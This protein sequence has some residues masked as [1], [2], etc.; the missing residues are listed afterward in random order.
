MHGHLNI[1]SGILFYLTTR[2]P[3]TQRL[4]R[5]AVGNVEPFSRHPRALLQYTAVNIVSPIT[6]KEDAG[7]TFL[8][9]ADTRH[10]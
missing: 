7:K 10:I 8:W 6:Y 3:T 1:K 9:L 4:F 5:V 2:I